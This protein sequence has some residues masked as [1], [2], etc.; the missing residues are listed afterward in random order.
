[1]PNDQSGAFGLLLRRHRR[2]AVLTQ[3]ALAERAGLSVRGIS[4]LERGVNAAPYLATI[5]R[6]CDALELS[7]QQREELERAVSRRRGPKVETT[8]FRLPAQY[9]AVLGR[10]RE[11]AFGTHLLRWEGKRLMTV[12]GPGGVGKTRL[13]LEI[14]TAIAADFAN[15]AAIISLE[16]VSNVQSIYSS[17]ASGLGIRDDSGRSVEE[18]LISFLQ[19]KEA[20]IVLD[21]FDR[22]LEG[23]ALA[24]RL[25][26]SCPKLKI[27]VASRSPLCITGEQE[28]ELKPLAVPEDGAFGDPAHAMRWPSV[29]LFVQRARQILPAF[30][31]TADNVAAIAGICRRLD[32]LPLAIELA[33]A[34]VKT[35]PPQ[36]LLEALDHRLNVLTGGPRDAAPHRQTMRDTIAWSYDF[37][38]SEAQDF[39][40]RLCVFN[41]PF[42]IDMAAAVSDPTA[43]SRG[44]AQRG[45]D[46]LV[47][48]SL[49]TV[50][51]TEEGAAR[52]SI[53]ETVREYG[54]EALREQ[55]EEDTVRGCLAEYWASIAETAEMG[56]HGSQQAEWM[57]RL[58]RD[59]ALVLGVLEWARTENHLPL[60]LRIA[61]ALWR[62]WYSRGY[63]TEGRRQLEGLLAA[64]AGHSTPDEIIAK[65]ARGAAVLAAVQG[66]YGRAQA[67]SV[68]ALE[69]YR[70]VGDRRGE[71]AVLVILGSV[72]HYTGE[73]AVAWTRYEQSLE[74][75]RAEGDEASIAVALNN[76]ANIA[77][78][79]GRTADSVLLYEESLSIKRRLGDVRGIGIALNNLGTL[80]LAQG[81]YGRATLFGEEALGLLRTLGDKDVT[82]AIDT[83]AR[84][85]LQHGDTARANALYDE[86]LTVSYAAGDRELIAFCLEGAGRVAAADGNV[87]R[88]V[89]LYGA[90]EALR[91][92]VGAPLPPSET[93]QHEASVRA[94]RNAVDG[95]SFTAAWERGTH[96]DVEEAIEFATL[97]TR[98][99]G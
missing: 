54:L 86:G 17:I 62:F 13:A 12:T 1:M 19:A 84:A 3:E 16:E 20:L 63:L 46:G 21:G 77:K 6:L 28:L 8:V 26:V 43:S 89:S 83:V 94:A 90:G 50:E 79:Q 78:E 57:S 51:E 99:G 34:R 31:L 18:N 14:A 61:G 58:D 56:L 91:S 55:G 22:L 42:D 15:G 45:I 37:L 40:R 41:A 88:A 70:R 95:T 73:Y 69:L 38:D 11:V 35:L 23:A 68:H 36:P 32:G 5:E 85:A 64:A 4:D 81:E 49:L 24:G 74:L 72:A 33:A 39:F 96:M 25:L 97:R 93:P 59:H 53:L 2:D 48:C 87:E 75:F 92:A 67:L 44:R 52:F 27:L 29:A 7:S 66:D 47:R 9:N 76:L 71:A 65:A 30:A 10:E 98:P 82:A 80:A 60:G